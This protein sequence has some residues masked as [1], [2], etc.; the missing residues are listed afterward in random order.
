MNE[1]SDKP[2]LIIDEDWKTQVERE[3][4]TFRSQPEGKPAEEAPAGAAEGDYPLPPASFDFLVTSLAT[5][6]MAALGQIPNPVTNEAKV[7]LPF[8]RLQIELLQVL[9]DKTKG[10]LTSP[11][12]EMLETALHQLRLLFVNVQD[13]LSQ[14]R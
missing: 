8:A 1:S 5:Q 2:K 14:S 10:N 6:I 4:A 12:A 11:E 7:S 13:Q 9:Q 3:R